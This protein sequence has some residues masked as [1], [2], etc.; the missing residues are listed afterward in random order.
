M[1]G[2][3]P[4]PAK[5]GL[6]ANPNPKLMTD[7]T[8]P[9]AKAPGANWSVCAVD[10]RRNIQSPQ[11]RQ[12]EGWSDKKLM[13]YLYQYLLPGMENS[14]RLYPASFILLMHGNFGKAGIP[15]G[16][17]SRPKIPGSLW[18]SSST[19][20]IPLGLSIWNPAENAILHRPYML[21]PVK[22]PANLRAKKPYWKTTHA[23]PSLHHPQDNRDMATINAS[24]AA[25]LST[26]A[27]GKR[28]AVH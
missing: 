4:A 14:C 19:T 25:P 18:T 26:S 28:W 13:D 22:C 16:Q 27:A 5:P 10:G 2:C 20:A 12:A 23:Y 21:F 11:S 15:T 9:P 8:L 17:E 24:M 7:D 3:H 6:Y 1:P